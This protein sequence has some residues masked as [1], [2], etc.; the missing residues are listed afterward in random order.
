MYLSVGVGG[1]F[2]S[3]SSDLVLA[4]FF[5]PRYEDEPEARPSIALLDLR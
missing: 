3:P 1:R 2:S 5:F 4:F